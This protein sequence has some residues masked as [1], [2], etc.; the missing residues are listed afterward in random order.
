MTILSIARTTALIGALLAVSGCDSAEE[1]AEKHYRSAI[2]LLESGDLD[3]ALVEFRNV[4]A[5]DEFHN[6]AR[7]AYARIARERGNIPD[8]Y[9]N[10]LRVA[11]L[12]PDNLEARLALTEIA[13]RLRNWQEAE[14]H[15]GVLKQANADIPGADAVGLVMEFREAVLAEDA[16]RIRELTRQA[17]ALSESRP[18]NP[19]LLRVII[20]GSMR[21]GDRETALRAID[22]GMDLGDDDRTFSRMKAA[23]LAEQEDYEA[24]ESHLR[25]MIERY[26]DDAEVKQA[27]VRM[28]V[29][30]GQAE[31]AEE[32]LRSQIDGPDGPEYQLALISFIRQIRGADAALAEIEAAIARHE[33]PA[34]YRALRAAILFDL[35][36]REGAIAELQDVVDKAEP[37]EQTDRYKVALARMLELTGNQV[38]ARQLVEEVLE[39]DPG[40]IDALK[41]SAEWLIEG[42][43]TDD[44][45]NVLREVLDRAPQDA[46][47][48]TL[49]A[50]AHS[51]NGELELAQDLLALAAEVSE[52]APEETLRL[53]NLLV[54]EDRLRPAEDA[55]I[56]ALRRNPGNL[57]LLRLLGRVYLLEEDWARAKQVEG[58]LRRQGSDRA[59]RLADELNLQ[60]VARREGRS[61]ALSLLERMAEDEGVGSPAQF[62][63]L[64]AKLSEGA[65]EEALAIAEEIAEANPDNPR[66]KFVL[67]NTQLALR[68]YEA[69]TG[70]LRDIVGVAPD[71]EQAW[72]QLARGL[73]ALGR[74]DEAIAVIDEGLAV[75]PEA[76]NLLWAKASFLERFNDI[77]G[78]IAIYESLYERNSA[79]LIVANNLASLLASYR[80]DQES[81]DRAFAVARRL[82]GTEVPPFQ[83]TYGWI[84]YRLG[85]YEE[86]LNYLRPAARALGNDPIVQYHLGAAYAALGQ[87]EKALEAFRAALEIA[88]DADPRPQIEQAR[89]EIERLAT[90]ATT[91]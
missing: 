14:R 30:L 65:G 4:L 62:A 34:P 20:E 15:Y 11:E 1:R 42:D 58:T 35:G 23:I 38:G 47:A 78:A 8:A 25:T 69:A 66:A 7:M 55:L 68:Q 43:K 24:L 50:R 67:A 27:L 29:G 28:L 56:N 17:I 49:M 76:P 16:P 32:F 33:D 53:A 44:A 79:S 12:A 45:I 5:L 81:L 51:R 18:D 91:E 77:D 63:L 86:A 72:V 73:N 19:V 54:G 70:T 26:P 57:D 89:A 59:V 46:D 64:R 31:R 74:A 85:D 60:I 84:L 52:Y 83:D 87:K 80:D 88:G 39:S 41:K 90:E 3:R 10:F 9:A 21:D 75:N 36:D 37:S 40:Q 61:Q 48:M 71:F 2:E 13:I 82:R 22:R 6:E